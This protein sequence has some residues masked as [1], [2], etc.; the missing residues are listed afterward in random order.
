MIEQIATLPA[1]TIR[2]S[3]VRSRKPVCLTI[4][5]CVFP[6]KKKNAR[7]TI[8][9]KITGVRL[10]RNASGISKLNRKRNANNSETAQIHKSTLKII[11]EG[12][13]D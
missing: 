7:T 5:V 12:V 13:V 9:M 11:Q 10:L 6:I 2:I 4:I 8:T 3:F 1:S